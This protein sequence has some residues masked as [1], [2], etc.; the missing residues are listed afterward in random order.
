MCKIMYQTI[1]NFFNF[2]NKILIIAQIYLCV[3]FPF[4]S[5][6]RLDRFMISVRDDN[7]DNNPIS[8]ISFYE[9]SSFK[10]ERLARLVS[11]D[12]RYLDPM[13]FILLF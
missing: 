5:R 4:I 9:I 10:V 1:E 12:K 6:D 2:L 8:L 3:E 11:Y 13:S 7:I